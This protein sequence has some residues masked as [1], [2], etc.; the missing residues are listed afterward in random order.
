M[1]KSLRIAAS[2]QSVCSQDFDIAGAYDV[3]LP[4]VECVKVIDEILGALKLGDY[5]IKV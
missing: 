2:V 1:C 4:E 3:M 5:V